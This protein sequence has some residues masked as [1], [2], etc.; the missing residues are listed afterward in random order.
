MVPENRDRFRTAEG[1]E[2]MIKCLKDRKFVS[3]SAVKVINFAIAGNLKNC[4]RLIEAGGL[5]YLFPLLMG[6]HM[7]TLDSKR[8]KKHGMNVYLL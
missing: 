8:D 7:P 5:K 6:R 1:F 2:L 4:E 3:L